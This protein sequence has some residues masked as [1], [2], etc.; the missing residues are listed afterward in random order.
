MS[1]KHF[2]RSFELP[3]VTYGDRPPVYFPW[4]WL[5]T[6]GRQETHS[7]S[8]DANLINDPIHYTNVILTKLAFYLSKFFIIIAFIL[9]K[10]QSK[11]S[12][13]QSPSASLLL[14]RPYW[15]KGEQADGQQIAQSISGGRGERGG[16]KGAGVKSEG[17]CSGLP[18]VHWQ[19]LMTT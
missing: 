5:T 19:N 10:L 2:F 7:S 9:R 11:C 17:S 8:T 4:K 6:L 18:S 14:S 16:V 13:W 12:S 1:W 3:D 15:W